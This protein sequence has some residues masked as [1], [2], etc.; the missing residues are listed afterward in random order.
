MPFGC[1]KLFVDFLG[2]LTGLLGIAGTTTIANER[3]SL[4][5]AIGGGKGMYYRPAN[6]PAVRTGR[7]FS[8]S[9]SA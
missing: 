9:T 8:L 4:F 3:A 7:G 6:S 5:P 1:P 2:V